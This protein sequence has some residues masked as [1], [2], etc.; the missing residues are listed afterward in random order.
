M[1]EG[2]SQIHKIE[3]V[4]EG[5]ARGKYH[6]KP[7]SKGEA[8]QLGK[9]SSC[10]TSIFMVPSRC[11]GKEYN[12][13]EY[14][15]FCEDKG[16][17][18]QVTTRFTPQQNGVVERKNQGDSEMAKSMM[19]EK[20]LPKHIWEEA[21]YMVVYLLKVQQKPTITRLHLKRGME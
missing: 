6:W 19:H 10:N 16:M 14:D 17:Y 20:S 15:K 3:G 18:R 13:I 12:S 7:F 5:C 2:L 4:C 8:R 1:V 11:H 21:V 9:S